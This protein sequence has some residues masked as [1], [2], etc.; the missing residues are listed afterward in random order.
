MVSLTTHTS[1][2]DVAVATWPHGLTR[3]I[4]PEWLAQGALPP[5]PIEGAMIVH[6]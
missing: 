4:C 3:V 1:S 2:K 6:N 5:V